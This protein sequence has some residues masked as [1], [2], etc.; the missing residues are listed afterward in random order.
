VACGLLFRF[1]FFIFA[2]SPFIC[3]SL[4]AL[5]S[6]PEAYLLPNNHPI[7]PVLDQIFSATRAILNLKTL[8]KAGFIY[9]KP[10]KF[11]NLI[12]ARHP[13]LPG[14][15]FKLYLDAQRYH[16]EKPEEYFWMLRIQGA[17]LV[18][19][20]IEA[21]H[22]Q[23]WVKVPQKWI[24][25][26]PKKPKAPKGY[27]AKESILVEED[28]Q[29][30]ASE[31]NEVIWKSAY[32]T[33]Q[34]LE[35]LYLILK[36]VGLSD[37]AKPDNMPFSYDGRVAFIDTQTHGRSVPYDQLAHWLSSENELFWEQLLSH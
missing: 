36:N 9:S 18:R 33:P 11:T 30:L 10:R 14:Y 2:F 31:D 22:L 17:N 27:L 24:Y 13:L 8:E 23:E 35:A 15:I 26:L 4:E 3:P 7:K 34:H 32:V 5:E 20:E 16:K 6:I 29:L 25:T 19:H 1:F 37:C 21:N 28:M 12:I